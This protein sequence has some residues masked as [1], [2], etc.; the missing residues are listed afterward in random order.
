[1]SDPAPSAAPATGRPVVELVGLTVRYGATVAV[2]AVDLAVPEGALTVLV[3][4]SG[5]GKTSL[6]RSIAG[7]EVPA[8]G[9]VRIDGR[10]VA[11]A[12]AW[13]PPERRRVAM[14]FQE[15][16]LFPHQT[17]AA[18]VGYGLGDVPRRERP[19]RVREALALVGMAELGGR[20]PDQLSGGQQQRVALARALA[21]RPRLVLLDEPFA[22]LDAALR[23]RLRDEVRQILAAAGA[24]ALMVTHDQAEAL[25]VADHL[26]VMEAGRVVQ[27]GT[28]DEVYRRPASEGVAAFLGE[29][30]LVPCRVTAGRLA[31]PWGE[32]AAPDA[33]AG[34]GHLLVRPEDLALLPGTGGPGCAGRVVG[35]RF[36]GHDLLDE[37]ELADGSRLQVRLLSS[38]THPVGAPVRLV[39]RPNDYRYFPARPAPPAI[40]RLGG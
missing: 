23:V 37:V 34:A 2:D 33:A 4:A 24:T 36:F 31:S 1:M 39:L 9:E 6:L 32:L 30:Q 25:S 18:N 38:V 17:V 7:F 22:S 21:P 12:G 16:A 13:V 29:G 10:T 11:G 3:G 19:A 15:G 20:Y 26:V 27:H 40:V 35:R 28:P 8:A 14:V 5:C